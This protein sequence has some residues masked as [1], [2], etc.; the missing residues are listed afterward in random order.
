[1][2]TLE[3]W[4]L[5]IFVGRRGSCLEGGVCQYPPVPFAA[6]AHRSQGLQ[7]PRAAEV[8]GQRPLA[9]RRLK[10]RLAPPRSTRAARPPLIMT[11]PFPVSLAKLGMFQLEVTIFKA[12]GATA[13]EPRCRSRVAARS[14]D[15]SV[16]FVRPSDLSMCRPS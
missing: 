2:T 1:M 12:L 15:D 3:P 4:V 9:Q 10:R 13:F 5:N 8:P 6:E 7:G 14:A 11:E 16:V